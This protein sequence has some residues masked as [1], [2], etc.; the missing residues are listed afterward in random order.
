VRKR[1]LQVLYGVAFGDFRTRGPTREAIDLFVPVVFGRR[2]VAACQISQPSGPLF[3]PISAT[4]SE[5][6]RSRDR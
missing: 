4:Q 1:R 3:G 6:A 5:S 2:Q